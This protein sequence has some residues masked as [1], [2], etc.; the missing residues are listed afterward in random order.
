MEPTITSEVV[1]AYSQCK[2]KAYKLL[3]TDKQRTPHA[4][5]SILEEEAGK[6]RESYFKKIM[7][8]NPDV[9]PYSPEGMKK[10]TPIMLEATLVSEDVQA[11][12]DVLTAMEETSSQRRHNYTPTLIVGTHRINKEQKLQLAFI[13]YVLS[14]VQKEKPTYG[15]IVGGGNK[16]YKTELATLYKDVGQTLRKLRDWT[17]AQEPESPPV[18]LNRHCP[19]CPFDKE[20]EAKAKGHD[21]L[22]LLKSMSEKEIAA[23]NKKGIFT[24]TQFAYTYRPRKRRKGQDNQSPKYH[25]SLKALAIRD[26]TIYVVEKPQV[27]QSSTRMFLDVEGVPDQDFYYLIGLLVG[28]HLRRDTFIPQWSQAS[29]A[30]AASDRHAV[31]C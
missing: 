9:V 26:N 20:C 16:S 5:I 22:S 2:L 4:Y 10:G 3:C 18:I 15:T 24:V 13:A 8:Q 27:P 7:G 11:Y 14:K 17:S 21:H 1:V 23:K 29:K 12:V 28:I 6:N 30:A 25:H 31:H 19:L